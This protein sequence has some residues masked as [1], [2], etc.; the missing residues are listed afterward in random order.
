MPS[1]SNDDSGEDIAYASENGESFS[2]SERANL[3]LLMGAVSGDDAGSRSHVQRTLVVYSGP[4]SLDRL[5]EKNGMYIDNM[6]YFLDHGLSCYD[7]DTQPPSEGNYAESV[8]VNY[9]FVVTQEVADYYTAPDGLITKIITKCEQAEHRVQKFRL[10]PFIKVI[11][12]Q[13]R[14]YDMESMRVVLEEIDVQSHY[15]NLLFINCGLVGPKFGPGTP[16]HIPSYSPNKQSHMTTHNKK[17]DET[18]VTMVPYSHWTQLYTSRL[19]DS[20][21]IVG[22]SINTHF[23]TFYPHV[24]SFLYAIRTDT[25]PILLSSGTIY[26]CG[27]TQEELAN[28]GEKRFELIE[29]YEVGMSTQLLKRGYKIATAFINRWEMGKSLVLDQNSTSG[30]ELDDQVSDIWYE[31][32]IRNLTLTMRKASKWWSDPNTI[33]SKEEDSFEYHKWDILPWDYYIFFKVSRLVPEDI[34]NIMNYNTLEVSSVP[35]IPND[36]RKSPHEFCL[37]KISH[38]AI[39]I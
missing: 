30:M 11:V 37:S 15:D 1:S 24:Q 8:I 34:Q 31:D 23:Y 36:P 9:A 33:L 3:R 2:P 21:R 6:N 12:R 35:V 5:K 29:R 14:C 20:I 22:H 13:D 38:R 28:N 32:G 18:E 7:D 10:E 26:D 25:V 27:L 19:T 4:T 16:T 39:T 17:N